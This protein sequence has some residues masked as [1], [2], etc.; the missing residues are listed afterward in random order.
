MRTNPSLHPKPAP[1]AYT[2][3]A[4]A[5]EPEPAS[6]AF[7]CIC[8]QTRARTRSLRPEPTPAYANEPE[9]AP[10]AYTRSVLGP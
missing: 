9:P 10:G 4:Y 2:T 3:P 7:T 8:K 6:G 1:G 5:N